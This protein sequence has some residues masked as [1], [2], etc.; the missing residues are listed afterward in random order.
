MDALAEL[1]ALIYNLHGQI[2]QLQHEFVG[3]LILDEAVGV[4]T[5]LCFTFFI[6]LARCMAQPLKPHLEECEALVLSAFEILDLINLVEAESACELWQR[7]EYG[8]L[9]FVNVHHE[10]F[11]DCGLIRVLVHEEGSVVSQL[12]HVDG[13]VAHR[14]E[15]KLFLEADAAKIEDLLTGALVLL[16]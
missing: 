2:S 8:I 10:Y 16:L 3:D 14:A 1:R 11:T 12:E 15:R 13:Q 6:V 7:C 4:L 5:L 9:A